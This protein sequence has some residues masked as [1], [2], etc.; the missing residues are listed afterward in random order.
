MEPT[1]ELTF[2]GG[3]FNYVSTRNGQ[4]YTLTFKEK[5]FCECYL[6]MGGNGTDAIIE[7]GYDV[8]GRAT[9]R[10]MASEYLAKPNIFEY[11]N[12]LLE[13]YGFNDDNVMKQHLFLLNQDGDLRTKAKAI[14]MFYDLQ[15]KFAPK[16]SINV[17]VDATAKSDN[18]EIQKARDEFNEKARQAIVNQIK[19]KPNA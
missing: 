1:N 12:M 5:M 16:K 7:A 17:T 11:V 6:E 8:N 2:E 19:N 10:G 13:K 4:S 15:G 3:T 9:A 18:P 14:E